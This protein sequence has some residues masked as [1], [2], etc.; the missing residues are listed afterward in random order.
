MKDLII[1][2]DGACSGNPGPGGWGALI[3]FDDGQKNICG[4][5]PQTTNNRMEM[6]A[7]LRA[8]EHLDEPR[9]V[10]LHT[11]SA[12]LSNA[13]KQGWIDNWQRNGWKTSSKK[14]VK[15]KDL[16]QALLV[17]TERHRVKWIKVKG[18][19]DDELN[20]EVDRL[21]VDAMAKYK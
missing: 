16:W 18:H 11:D 7:A 12:Y 3:F 6:T 2:T 13:F 1:Y 14:P 19:A 21:A 5:E 17:Q 15:N 9:A 10:R 4:G 20:N 8:L